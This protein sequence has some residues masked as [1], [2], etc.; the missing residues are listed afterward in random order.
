VGLQL[1]RERL[2]DVVARLRS[3]DFH[4][5]ATHLGEPSRCGRPR[6]CVLG[7]FADVAAA[8]GIGMWDKSVAPYRFLGPA[9]VR[10]FQAG[11]GLPAWQWGK[12]HS[13]PRD[14]WAWF[15]ARHEPLIDARALPPEWPPRAESG[16][17]AFLLSE[18]NDLGGTFDEIADVLE[19]L[20]Q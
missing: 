4:Q 8:A 9:D 17:E 11:P 6:R 14:V 10:A 1:H 5:V 2:G 20:Y 3:G 13:L 7:V 12:R 16:D 19:E 15:G 18:L